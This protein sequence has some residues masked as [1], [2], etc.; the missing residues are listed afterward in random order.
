MRFVECVDHDKLINMKLAKAVVGNLRVVED[1]TTLEGLLK[2]PEQWVLEGR[3]I[4]GTSAA[5]KHILSLVKLHQQKKLKRYTLEVDTTEGYRFV[6]VAEVRSFGAVLRGI[7]GSPARFEDAHQKRAARL[8]VAAAE[9]CG[10]LEWRAGPILFRAC[11]IQ[12]P[13]PNHLVPFAEFW[14]EQ[15]SHQPQTALELLARE[16]ARQH[17]LPFFH[18]DIKPYH[19]FVDQTDKG[20]SDGYRLKWIDFGRA[21]FWMSPR[22]RIINLY[23]VARFVLPDDPAIR[24]QFVAAYCIAAKL[25]APKSVSK[26][27]ERF[28]AYKRRVLP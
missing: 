23:Q 17:A 7:V 18:A 8:G 22:K 14:R 21:A 25:S 10:F 27:V 2:N 11:Q 3:A 15:W 9:S 26:R 28:L 19:A 20:S 16:L 13:V 4:L 5:Q 1:R 12:V 6:K 24:E